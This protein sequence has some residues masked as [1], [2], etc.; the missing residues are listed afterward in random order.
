MK[1]ILEKY[2]LGKPHNLLIFLRFV[3]AYL[4]FLS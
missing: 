3:K 1:T 2:R 4:F